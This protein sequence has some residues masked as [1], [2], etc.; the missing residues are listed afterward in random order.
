MV[1]RVD[2]HNM[3]PDGIGQSSGASLSCR[4]ARDRI[5]SGA[6]DELDP[7]DA[8]ALGDHLSR[9]DEC[10]DYAERVAA[11]TRT[12]RLRPVVVGPDPVVTVLGRMRPPRLGRGGWMRPALAWVGIVV[13]VQSVRPLVF[14]T[15]DGVPTHVARHVGAS[16]LALA[17][18]FG[19]AAWRPTRAYGLV[20][21]VAALFVATLVAGVLD[22]LA[23]A[24]SAMA[25][26][27]HIAELVGMV[28]L[29]SVAGSPGLE[30]VRDL[31]RLLRRGGGVP[32]TTT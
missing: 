13:A 30:R 20:P 32:H 25:E 9:C 21:L 23:G 11:L 19:Y 3:D 16:A 6:D 26:T 18:G 15:L 17:I 29:W 24:R 2:R 27:V 1:T 8:R 28:L 10:A 5:S 14:G 7:V 22:T 31:G 4:E 12:I